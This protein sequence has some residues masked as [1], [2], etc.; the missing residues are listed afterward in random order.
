MVSR[1]AKMP[2][3]LAATDQNAASSQTLTPTPAPW[4]AVATIGVGAFALVTA[5]FLPV[6]LLPQ[7]AS[8]LA[9]S[10][11]QAG[12]MI[13]IPGIVAACSALL[14]VSLAKT[15]DRRHVLWILLSL[16]VV[17][18]ALMACSNG[19]FVL[20]SGR[21][22]LGIAVGGFWTIG[23]SLGPRL[24]PD[25]VGRATSIIFS[26]VTLGTVAGV[27]AGTLL[28]GLFGWR[29]A[30]V[31]FAALASLVVVAL[32]LLLPSIRPE[33][34]SGFT[35]LPA[36]LRLPKVQVGLVAVM[37]IFIGQFSAYTYITPY[38]NQISG[39]ESSRLSFLLL[40]YGVA[41]IFGN[42]LCGW[43][44]DRDVRLAVLGTS[45]LLGC[46]MLLLVSMGDNPLSAIA[47]VIAWGFGFGMLPIAIQSWIFSAAP[48]RLESVAALFV[49]IAQL[50]MGGGALLGGVTVDHYGI[51]SAVW[52]G[53]VGALCGAIWIFARFP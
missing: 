20:L 34:T 42:L 32:V 16:L 9:I 13:T 27:P 18:N 12:L 24:R 5:E 6:G 39:I 33:K 7:I 36:V 40:G 30:F 46:S 25:S 26:G 41:G 21:V 48:D 10:E 45:L 28:G 31:A 38:L 14:T 50:A 19:L 23:V 11:G 37:L 44:V 52:V 2:Q 15:F 22:L 43:F 47:A 53:A 4:S 49:S 3:V 1:F 8:D 51:A 35:Q 29:I 17:S